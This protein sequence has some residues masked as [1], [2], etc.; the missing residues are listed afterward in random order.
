MQL[1][2]LKEGETILD[3]II[4]TIFL[5]NFFAKYM[6]K[7]K[8]LFYLLNYNNIGTVETPSSTFF[9]PVGTASLMT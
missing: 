5:N 9:L 8:L 7:N 4:I 3:G 2:F 6:L 1:N